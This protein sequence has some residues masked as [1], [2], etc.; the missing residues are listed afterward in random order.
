MAH[1]KKAMEAA[2]R[3]RMAAQV[4]PHRQ[5]LTFQVR[6]LVSLETKHL[7]VNTL[8]S[9]KL[10]PKWNSPMRVQQDINPAAY[11]LEL[12]R[13]WRAHNVFHV[14]LLKPYIVTMVKL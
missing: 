5:E 1:A 12:P 2:A 13:T 14:S 10:F 7:M 4:D 3:Q 6:D 9:K 11:M 8:P